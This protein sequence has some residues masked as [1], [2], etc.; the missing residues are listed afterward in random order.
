MTMAARSIVASTNHGKEYRFSGLV[1]GPRAKRYDLTA[2]Q[3]DEL[4]RRLKDQAPLEIEPVPTKV[5][6][7]ER[8]AKRQIRELERRNADLEKELAA[9]REARAAR[10]AEYKAR[11]EELEALLADATAASNG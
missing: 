9:A 6:T 2:E 4:E 10:E 3:A 5:A 1:F 8:E 11:V 7:V